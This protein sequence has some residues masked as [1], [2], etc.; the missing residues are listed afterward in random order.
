MLRGYALTKTELTPFL[1]V[2]NIASARQVVPPEPRRM[3]RKEKT[4]W[5]LP[6]HD[7]EEELATE[8]SSPEHER[9]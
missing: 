5:S 9:S 1:K 8:R 2:M 3:N 7:R 6:A 4:S